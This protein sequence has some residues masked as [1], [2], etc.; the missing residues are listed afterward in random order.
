[1]T[2]TSLIEIVTSVDIP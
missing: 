2:V 1:M